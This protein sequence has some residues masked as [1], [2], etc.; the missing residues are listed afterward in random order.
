MSKFIKATYIWLDGA[1]PTQQLRSKTK[2]IREANW[3]TDWSFDGSSTWQAEGHSSDLILRPRTRYSD[4]LGSEDDVLILCEVYNPDNTP[5]HTNTR[6]KLVK[7][8]EVHSGQ[9]PWAG[10]EQEYVLMKYDQP[11]G[12]HP[13]NPQGPFYCSV[14]ADVA[15]G[16]QIVE[17][18]T[19]ACLK[20]GL[21]FYGTNAEVMPGQWEFQIGY[22]GDANEDCGVLRAADDLWV[23]RYLLI[24]IAERHGVTVSFAPKVLAGD[25]NG[26]GMHTNFSTKATRMPGTGMKAIEAAVENLAWVHAEHI[27]VYGA[28][29]EFRLTGKH[30]TCNINE[31]K[32]GN[33]DRGCSIRIPLGVLQAGYG[34]FEDRRPAANAN[35]YDVGLALVNTVLGGAK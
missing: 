32:S 15:F 5:H 7:A 2:M 20:A 3:E 25:W 29:N 1:Q 17:E 6:A 23:A 21:L 27:A 8:L 4:P 13:L 34:Y 26:S 33:S 9:D 22:R 35:P 14:G 24:L 16:R 12:F 11:L 31:F 30:E 19:A 28:G 10:F 18:H